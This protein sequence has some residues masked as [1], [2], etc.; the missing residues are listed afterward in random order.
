MIN[1]IPS[2]F[3]RIYDV[4]QIKRRKTKLWQ[5]KMKSRYKMTVLYLS[6]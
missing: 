1:G 2:E 5:K 3:D 6:Q 4:I